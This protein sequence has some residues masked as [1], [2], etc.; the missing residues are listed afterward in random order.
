MVTRQLG[1]MGYFDRESCD[2]D[3]FKVL[4]SQ[5][6]QAADVPLAAEVI[7]NVPIYDMAVLGAHLED[8][9]KR[10]ALLAEWGWVFGHSAGVI[11]LRGA[12]ADT[13]PIDRATKVFHEIIEEEKSVTSGADHFAA[14]GAND[15]IWNAL[16][17]QCMKD[18][19]G[20]A[21][22]VANTA[23]DAAC[24]AW[25]GPHY[26]M[27]TQVNQVRPG[28]A[29]QVAHRDYHLGFMTYDKAAAYPMNAHLVSASLTLQG[30]IAHCD[31]PIESGPTKLLPFSQLY[32]PGYLA[33]NLDD[34]RAYF[35]E[36]CIQ[37]PL[38]KGD[39]LFFNPAL[40]HAAGANTSKDILRMANL[41]QYSSPFGRSIETVDRDAMSRAIFPALLKLKAAGMSEARLHA[42][43]AATAEGYSFPTNLDNDPP[44]GGL[45][46]KTQADILR[47]AVAE[48][49]GQEALDAELTALQTRQRA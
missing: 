7:K 42:A 26:Q 35:E 15:R 13:A 47:Q 31:M 11:A 27:T 39:A 9:D 41:I 12:Y 29:A 24:E 30:A 33:A 45:A 23:I 2:L 8:T 36:A 18:P 14:A 32:G 19:D 48:D 20:F 44:I 46:P 10:R 3:E 28:G 43:I 25:L 34:H 17:K 16:Q 40:F 49:W 5:N 4:T 22:Y 38:K 37:V 21:E 6:L 1:Y